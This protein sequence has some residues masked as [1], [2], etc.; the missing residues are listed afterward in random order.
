MCN[1]IDLIIYIED[2]AA[3]TTET[4]AHV[5]RAHCARRTIDYCGAGRDDVPCV[6]TD[7]GCLATTTVVHKIL[8]LSLAPPVPGTRDIV[9][10]ACVE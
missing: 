5:F 6:R 3:R 7:G 1:K 8:Q 10:C 2:G 9:K 4:L